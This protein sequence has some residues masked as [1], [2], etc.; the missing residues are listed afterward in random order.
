MLQS[1]HTRQW[2]FGY[3]LNEFQTG[4]YKCDILNLF[5]TVK[6]PNHTWAA[7]KQT[8]VPGCYDVIAKPWAMMTSHADELT[9]LSCVLWWRE[10]LIIRP[11]AGP[12]EPPKPSM[13]STGS[14]RMLQWTRDYF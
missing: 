12:I 10:E 13:R 11:L 5:S 4:G 8:A 9:R 2:C 3:Q 14:A 6:Q 7:R 1:E